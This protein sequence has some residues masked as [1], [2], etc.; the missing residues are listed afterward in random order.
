MSFLGNDFPAP[1]GHP[2]ADINPQTTLPRPESV[3]GVAH[4]IR[5]EVDDVSR[6]VSVQA[7]NPGMRAAEGT[8]AAVR[9]E[10]NRLPA[11][12]VDVNVRSGNQ[13]GRQTGTP[14]G[15]IWGLQGE[16][17]PAAKPAVA[18]GKLALLGL[19]GFLGWRWLSKHK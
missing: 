6:S 7:T 4:T 11:K 9:V 17:D 1:Q 3:I 2:S 12:A 5:S 15:F 13:D 8:G 14:D 18:W 16:G 19:A 10:G